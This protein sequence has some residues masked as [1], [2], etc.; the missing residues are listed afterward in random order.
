MK[1]MSSKLFSELVKI[2]KY[3]P[4]TGNQRL[5]VQSGTPYIP[6]TLPPHSIQEKLNTPHFHK[7]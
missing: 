7:Q 4:S 2:N 5:M 1:Y 3:F 6:V